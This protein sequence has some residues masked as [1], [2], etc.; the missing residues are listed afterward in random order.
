MTHSTIYNQ[1][2][3]EAIAEL[4]D[5]IGLDRVAIEEGC[6]AEV[7]ALTAEIIAE[8]EAEDAC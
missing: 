3:E 2:R 5:L 6:T 1:A 7:D 8:W 4:V